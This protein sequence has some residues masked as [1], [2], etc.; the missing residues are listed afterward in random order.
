MYMWLECCCRQN[1]RANLVQNGCR[2]TVLRPGGFVGTGYDGT[3]FAVGNNT[4]ACRVDTLGEQIVTGGSGTALAKGKVVL[5]GAA[6]VAMAF[7]S[8]GQ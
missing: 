2:T 8:H 7:N 4:D 3:L 1:L 6:L 5:P